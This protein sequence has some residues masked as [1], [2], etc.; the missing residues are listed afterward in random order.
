MKKN[1]LQI[2]IC[3]YKIET[4]FNSIQELFFND[5]LADLQYAIN[6]YE[7]IITELSGGDCKFKFCK[8]KLDSDCDHEET[9]FFM[10]ILKT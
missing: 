2:I 10:I 1:T 9:S 3:K 6:K 8:W 4:K 7:E 5:N